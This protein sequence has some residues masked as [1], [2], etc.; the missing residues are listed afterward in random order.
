METKPKEQGDAQFPESGGSASQHL[1]LL[2]REALVLG[3]LPHSTE[4]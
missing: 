4:R 3:D 1:E 2:G